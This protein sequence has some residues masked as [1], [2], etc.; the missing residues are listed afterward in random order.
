MQITKE[1]TFLIF[2]LPIDILAVPAIQSQQYI[3]L[4]HIFTEG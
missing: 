1:Y 3:Q 2:H 4:S